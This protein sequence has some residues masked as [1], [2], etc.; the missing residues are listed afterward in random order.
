MIRVG[1]AEAHEVIRAG[2]RSVLEAADDI[3]IAGEACDGDGA[4]H[5]VRTQ[6]PSV[7]TLGLAMQGVR[8]TN[9][10]REIRQTC[11]LSRILV[12]T[13]S[14]RAS[15]ASLCFAAGA[16]GFVV[17]TS[18]THE[19]LAA[20]RKVASGRVYI[21]LEAAGEF[22]PDTTEA[23]GSLLHERLTPTELHTFLRIACGQTVGEIAGTL[24]VSPK[25]VSTHRANIMGKMG[26][27]S[28][29]DLV[30]YAIA[31]KLVPDDD[32]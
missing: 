31:Y 15:V 22:F 9:L 7:L 19:L 6:A 23:A 26:L 4:L 12:V 30:R 24:C 27:R 1:I 13:R 5:L 18:P 2:I 17:K 29:A 20:V 21:N 25:T 16:S 3:E 32:P 11:P 28:D 8:G 10:I 14:S